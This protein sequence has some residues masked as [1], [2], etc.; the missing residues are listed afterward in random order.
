[1]QDQRTIILDLN[2]E[3]MEREQRHLREAERNLE[4]NLERA[5]QDLSRLHE[6]MEWNANAE[7]NR[8]RLELE[9]KI[10]AEN[11]RALER[12]RR[13]IDNR[14]ATQDQQTENEFIHEFH[15]DDSNVKI[16]IR[17]H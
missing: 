17:E 7:A 9:I 1:M 14:S 15:F 16:H 3:E 8:E 2:R 10:K 5:L 6:R 13:E 12:I 11:L 4:R